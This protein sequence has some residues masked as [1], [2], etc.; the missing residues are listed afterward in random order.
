MAK[1]YDIDT[2]VRI[3]GGLM[4]Y[5][6]TSIPSSNLLVGGNIT[7]NIISGGTA[8]ISIINGTTANI[9][10]INSTGT[11]SGGTIKGNGAQLI[12]G[13]TTANG[14][15][16]P[17]SNGWAYTHENKTGAQGHIPTGGSN[18]TFL[19]GD[20]TWVTPTD[21]NNYVTSISGNGNGTLYVNRNGLTQLTLD[22]SHNHNTLYL[23]LGGGT[24]TGGLTFAPVSSNSYVASVFSGNAFTYKSYINFNAGPSSN[25][26]GYIM[27]ETSSITAQQNNGVIHLSPTDDNGRGDYVSIHGSND[28]ETIKIHTDGYVETPQ[29]IRA[30]QGFA[31]SGT[32]VIGS[33]ALI[34]WA[35]IK[36]EPA[37]YAPSAHTHLWADIT[38][39]PSTFAPST[40]THLWADI[41]D[42]P[43]TFTPSTHT[44][45][46]A[47]IT[48]KP[49]TFAPSTHNH[50]DLYYT[51]TEMNTLL[52]GKDY[53]GKWN[54][55]VG[56][57]TN[58]ITASGN[59]TVTG[60]GATS[61]SY[62]T[63]TLTI[64]STDTNTWRPIETSPTTSATNS[65]ASSWAKTHSE[66]YGS[67]SH[68]PTGGT[69]SQFLRGDGTWQ[70]PTDTNTWR[71]V[72]A[73]PI[74]GNTANS[75]SSDWAYDHMNTMGIGA[76]VPSG[77]SATTF[78]RGDGTWVT[79][80]DTNTNNYVSGVSSTDGG[81]G[82]LTLTRSG[83]TDLS[84][85]LGHNHDSSYLKL[86]GGTVTGTITMGS[87][88]W[89]TGNAVQTPAIMFNTS[90]DPM[91]IYGEQYGSN[92]SRLV[93]QSS[94]DGGTTDYVTIRNRHFSNG[95]LDVA[96]FY[97][98]N[99]DINV[100]LNA[101]AGLSVTGNLSVTGTV[102]GVDVG[103]HATTTGVSGH[104]PTGGTTSQ[105][106]R[107]DGSWATP[108][109][110]NTNN[111]VTSI[112]GNGN[113]TFYLNRSGLTQLTL[114]LSHT[115][116]QYVAN[117]ATNQ[118]VQTGFTMSGNAYVGGSNASGALV[119]RTTN[120]ASAIQLAG[121][122]A[123]QLAGT[124]IYMNASGNAKFSGSMT[125]NSIAVTSTTMVT[126]L[127]SEMVG[128][129][130]EEELAKNESIYE[131]GGK[132]VYTG[133]SS[134]QQTV[135]NMTVLVSAGTV[136]TDSG[137]R[138]VLPNTSVAIS[139]SS[140]TYDRKD[141]IYVKGSSAGANEGELAVATGT[142]ASTA[143]EPS[144]PSDSVKLAV[145]LVPRAIGTIQ[146]QYI[147]DAR[148][149]KPLIGQSGNAIL[150]N[151]V[152]VQGNLDSTNGVINVSR[153][154]K[155]TSFAKSITISAGSKTSTWTHN[156]ALGTS[157]AVTLSC[158]SPEPHV[159]WSSKATNAI[160]VNLDDVC[161]TDVTIDV[162]LVAY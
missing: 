27:H 154:L 110:T 105:Y 41:T 127:N 104:I 81:N 46:W 7:G 137:L 88:S 107:G 134:A 48:D 66:T 129:K 76:H 153:P 16:V 47:D 108:P 149:W 49:S 5:G 146:T 128:G 3:N 60:N 64:S 67:G 56:G 28:P 44:H 52:A 132:G 79:P 158:N 94:D 150:N 62:S 147:T 162:V 141:V 58:G 97:R 12:V 53:Y 114:D 82:T 125:A 126:N 86:T 65:I 39:K 83:L 99:V 145:V 98:G 30:D 112:S 138:V 21:T 116:S 140:T 51:E 36:N 124:T 18:T 143:L 142:P 22:L 70:T 50:D 78:L 40:H 32:V 102:D 123:T 135:P 103:T 20:N 152:Y 144:I 37:T 59:V 35:R 119:V 133:L 136:Y 69:T 131:L 14:G 109:D 55:I 85:D 160:T 122:N 155:G 75:V 71:P 9:T 72:D 38:D 45:L 8:Q 121:D 26:P 100:L 13:G 24:L 95:D 148:E 17:I 10:D 161:D 77:G 73:T 43:S 139:T 115:H 120:G 80:T 90:G 33:D 74:N 6:D 118:I 19:R 156:L 111:Y 96:D 151:T 68:V 93:V 1:Y 54:L 92:M 91:S 89:T 23:G 29:Q 4:V 84:V 106:L 25:D 63:G 15:T 11:I 117:N 130:T 2:S 31:V 113:G 159:Y 57:A 101:K 87:A 157:Y 34:D 42:K 61:V